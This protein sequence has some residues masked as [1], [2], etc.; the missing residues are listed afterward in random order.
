MAE[1]F[2]NG[3]RKALTDKGVTTAIANKYVFEQLYDSTK[4]IAKQICRER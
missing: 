3:L 2:G 1:P 4:T